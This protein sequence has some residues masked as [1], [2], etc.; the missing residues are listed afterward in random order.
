MDDHSAQRITRIVEHAPAMLWH[1]TGDGQLDY[2]SEGWLRF[3]GRDLSMELAGGWTESV[4]PDDIARLTSIHAEACWHGAGFSTD[5]RLRRFDGKYRQVRWR[6]NPVHESGVLMA[7]VGTC[8][9]LEDSHVLETMRSAAA[10][11][12]SNAVALR[13]RFLASVSHE[14]RTPLHAVLGWA[15]MMRT[16]G[17]P[18]HEFDRALSVI[19]RNATTQ[20]RLVDDLLDVSRITTGWMRLDIR[21]V[22]L[23]EVIERAL[24]SIAPALQSRRL[25]VHRALDQDAGPVAGD[26]DRLQQVVW[27]LLSNAIKFTPKGGRIQIALERVDSSAVLTVSDT[28]KGFPK[29]LSH[30][31]FERFSRA[32]STDDHGLGLGLAI[33]R[34]IVELHGGSISATSDGEGTGATFCVTLPVSVLRHADREAAV[35]RK[36]SD[37]PAPARDCPPKL[38]GTIVLVVDDDPEARELLTAMLV[39]CGATAVT[40]ASAADALRSL[41]RAKP[42]LIVCDLGMPGE[43]G[44]AFIEQVRRRPR[45]DGGRIPAAAVTGY[46]TAKDRT[47][48]LRAG[49]QMHLGK[50]VDPDE[51]LAALAVLA[52][53]SSAMR[54]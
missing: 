20:A 26:P 41:D 38:D 36:S 19:E 25:T 6:A 32:A 51:L 37:P 9:D 39:R 10:E 52:E 28:G 35:R 40:A 21:A 53:I 47:R 31:I 44:V 43:D 48:V 8:I 49:F 45:E 18:L 13:D 14:L 22:D 16:G 24:E 7:Y 34:H 42:D 5:F 27:N 46:S 11:Q 50:P 30:E 23:G 12:M 3:V 15:R 29:H 54:T 33:A 1:A 17:L 2:F 4:H